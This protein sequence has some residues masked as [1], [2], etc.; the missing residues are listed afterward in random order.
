MFLIATS[1]F[2]SI[3]IFSALLAAFV[4]G[5]VWLQRQRNAQRR[6][7][8]RQLAQELD[9]SFFEKD[10]SGLTRQL[11]MFD[12]F[13]RERSRWARN[14]KV[15]SVMRGRVGEAEVF[16]FDYAYTVHTG[17]SSHTVT[18]TVFFANDKNWYLPD[19]RLKPET[20]WQK[21]LSKIGLRQDINFEDNPDF[22]SQF[23]LTG[24][25]EELIRKKFSADLQNFL[26]E[27][28][29]VHIEG[30]NYY[31]I[32]YKP[33]KALNADEAQVFFEHCCQLT[34]LLQENE[35]SQILELAELKKE[36][37]QR[38]L[39]APKLTEKKRRQ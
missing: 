8:M 32:T 35:N 20:W 38:P 28:P 34:K 24:E 30:S 23:W 19:F 2:I 17:K 1:A 27:R 31:L 9:L 13:Q 26:T 11:Q 3:A 33:G 22:S 18:Q 5:A 14:G 21:V 36:G 16:M 10:T 6:A 7:E 12:L 39:K 4:G 15:T 37:M 25:I 29:P